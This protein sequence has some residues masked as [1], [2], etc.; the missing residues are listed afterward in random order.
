MSIRIIRRVILIANATRPGTVFNY[1]SAWRKWDS[2][3]KIDPIICPMRDV[4]Q[5]LTECFQKGFK[6]NTIAGFGSAISAYH[7]PIQSI[8]VDKLLGFLIL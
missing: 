6:Y 5:F 8:S 4:V 1:K 2:R 3:R 7:D